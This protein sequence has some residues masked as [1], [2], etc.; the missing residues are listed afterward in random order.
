[1]SSTAH[2][3]RHLQAIAGLERETRSTRSVIEPI[4]DRVTAPAGSPAVIVG[5]AVWFAVWIG[6]NSL[7]RRGSPT[8]S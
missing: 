1:M 7:E 4:T 3:L 6:F 5:H 2:Q 8:S